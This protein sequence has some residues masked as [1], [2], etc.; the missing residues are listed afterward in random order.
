MKLCI[1]EFR[2]TW[3]A[4]SCFELECIKFNHHFTG[5]ITC[6]SAHV[7]SVTPEMCIGGGERERERERKVLYK[8]R[9]HKVK[10]F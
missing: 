1:G 7:R 10:R 9:R 6:V 4:I 5:R 3:P 2:E 8:E